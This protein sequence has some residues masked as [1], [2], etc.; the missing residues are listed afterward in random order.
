MLYDDKDLDEIIERMRGMGDILVPLNYPNTFSFELEDDLSIFKEREAIIDGIPLFLNYQKSDYKKYFIET[1]QIFGKTTPFLP[2]NLI[3]KIGKRF[4][5]GHHLSLVEIFK[6][7]RKIY[8]WSVCVDKRGRP[9]PAP[10]KLKIE[11]C[12]FEGFNYSY[13]QPNQINFY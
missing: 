13:L 11:Q 5:G 9:I 4:L 8:I 7:N 6:D 10:Y 1:V 3:C 12:E 2:F